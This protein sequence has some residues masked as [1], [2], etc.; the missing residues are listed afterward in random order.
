MANG[1]TL[2]RKAKQRDAIH[3]WRP[4]ENSTGPKSAEGKAKVAQNGR[5]QFRHGLN[6]AQVQAELRALRALIKQS[7]QSCT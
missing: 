4:W 1:W 3:R 5:K 7:E 6:S 2:A